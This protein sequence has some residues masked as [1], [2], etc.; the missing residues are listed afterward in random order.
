MHHHNRCP[1]CNSVR[2]LIGRTA[3]DRL[4]LRCRQCLCRWDLQGNLVSW[5]VHCPRMGYKRPY[6]KRVMN[7]RV[8]ELS[9]REAALGSTPVQEQLL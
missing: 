9:G 7:A 8:S 2:D 5:S 1:H 3:Y 6:P 4:Q